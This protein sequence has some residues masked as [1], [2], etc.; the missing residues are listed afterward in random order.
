MALGIISNKDD[1]K[2]DL[3]VGN[4]YKIEDYNQ[5]LN[6]GHTVGYDEGKGIII[7]DKDELISN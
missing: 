6:N 5:H 1:Y 4:I 7:I 2:F 3:A